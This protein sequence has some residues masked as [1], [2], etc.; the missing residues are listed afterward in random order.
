MTCINFQ[1]NF[2]K[3]TYLNIYKEFA[4]EESLVKMG[5]KCSGDFKQTKLS[6]K[7]SLVK[8]V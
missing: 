3:N 1:V 2:L 7:F 6:A 5:R 4:Q 8:V